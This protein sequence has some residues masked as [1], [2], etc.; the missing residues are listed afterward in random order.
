LGLELVHQA[1]TASVPLFFDE[2]LTSIAPRRK[3]EWG[4]HGCFSIDTC[5][6]FSYSCH[7]ELSASAQ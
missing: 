1:M 4:R 5:L 6:L 2:H 7:N 3:T